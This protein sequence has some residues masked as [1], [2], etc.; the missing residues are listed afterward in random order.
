MVNYKKCVPYRLPIIKYQQHI[1]YE[2]A[3]CDSDVSLHQCRV[4]PDRVF[5]DSVIEEQDVQTEDSHQQR[6]K[7]RHRP[8]VPFHLLLVA[9][10]EEAVVDACGC[11]GA[12]SVE[13]PLEGEETD[14]ENELVEWVHG[15][16]T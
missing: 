12:D 13:E 9:E 4:S 16:S 3:C 15:H 11:P 7:R 8:G 1:R 2:V 6:V 14:G 10:A 5:I